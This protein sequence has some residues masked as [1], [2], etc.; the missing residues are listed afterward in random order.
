MTLS[1]Q[2]YFLP[3]IL[4]ECAA[5]CPGDTVTLSGTI[6]PN[7]ANYVT[8]ATSL[9]AGYFITYPNGSQV[10]N[11]NLITL[12]ASSG[13]QAFNTNFVVPAG[14]FWQLQWVIVGAQQNP[15]NIVVFADFTLSNAYVTEGW[16]VLTHST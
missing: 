5:A 14:C 12:H 10:L 9:I 8:P 11:G 16:G 1:Q 6:N 4:G 13:G 7:I 2:Q 3:A 15:F